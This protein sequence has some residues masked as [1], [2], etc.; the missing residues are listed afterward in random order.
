VSWN[1]RLFTLLGMDPGTD[2]AEV[3]RFMSFVHPDDRG[4]LL[5]SMN[6]ALRDGEH[7]VESFRMR[8][9]GGETRVGARGRVLRD[10]S[11]T[12]VRMLGVNFVLDRP[13]RSSAVDGE[14]E[15]DGGGRDAA[16]D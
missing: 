8:L 3:D 13:L 11:G 14:R 5:D 9:P 16:D 10:S 12:A 4:R 2:A 15:A 7:F 1:D 6:A